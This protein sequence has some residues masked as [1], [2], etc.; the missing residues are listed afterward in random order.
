MGGYGAV[1]C[2][3]HEVARNGG[4]PRDFRRLPI[5]DF[6]DQ[7]DIVLQGVQDSRE[8]LIRLENEVEWRA[9]TGCVS[10][11]IHDAEDVR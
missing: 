9:R 7:Y 2:G 11:R 1:N 6:T 4:V 8:F 5:P 3:E 10:H